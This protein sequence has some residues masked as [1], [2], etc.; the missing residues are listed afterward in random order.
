M[1]LF[2]ARLILAVI[3]LGSVGVGS[4]DN[5]QQLAVMWPPLAMLDSLIKGL[6]SHPLSMVPTSFTTDCGQASL[7]SEKSG[8]QNHYRWNLTHQFSPTWTW[9]ISSGEFS[10]LI[11]KFATWFPPTLNIS[12]WMGRGYWGNASDNQGSS[13]V[14]VPGG[15]GNAYY[16]PTRVCHG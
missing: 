3:W 9:K 14:T 16:I 12:S 5:D 2:F 8:S 13:E 7:I 6:M 10:V 1:S 15:R 11:L 4:S